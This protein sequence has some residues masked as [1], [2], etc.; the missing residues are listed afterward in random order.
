MINFF[1]LI[2]VNIGKIITVQLYYYLIN[3]Q[4]NKRNMGTHHTLG[5]S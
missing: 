4:D 1:L 2:S 3:L 5:A